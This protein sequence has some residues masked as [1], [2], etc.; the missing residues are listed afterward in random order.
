MIRTIKKLGNSNALLLDRTMMDALQAKTGDDVQ[1]TVSGNH[2][3]IAPIDTG[4][5]RDE[6]KA[7]MAR[8]RRRYGKVFKKLA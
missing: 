3:V 5:G 8:A 4:I 2:I 1:V 7:C 6:L